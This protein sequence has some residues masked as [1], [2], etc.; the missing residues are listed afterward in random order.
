VPI[1]FE[2]IMRAVELNGAAIEMNRQAFAWGRLAVVNPAAVAEAAGVIHNTQTESER[3]PHNLQIL[4]PGDWETSDMAGPSAPRGPDNSHEVRGLQDAGSHDGNVAFLP[5]DDLRLSRSLDE[6]IQRRVAFLTEYQNAAYAKRYRALV[7]QVRDAEQLRAPGSTALSEAVAR[8]FFKLMAYKDEYE[9]A[10]LYTS[11][12]FEQRIRDTFDGDFKI[13]FNLAP[14]LFAKK[15]AEGRLRKAEYGPWMFTA[16]RLLA[17][18]RGL[19]GSALDV[20]GYTAERRMERQLIADYGRTIDELLAGLSPDNVAL[21]VDIAS[22]PELIRGYGHI[23]ERHHA[24]AMKHF[25]HLLAAW[26][27]PLLERAAA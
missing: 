21:A 15:D 12:D 24:E 18:L 26:R 23:K 3:T 7:D 4:P 27:N 14:P 17:R 25:D 19:R 16:F 10:R 8:Y 2:A 6:L 13:H 5:L 1:S 22:V 20:F 11:G 9:V